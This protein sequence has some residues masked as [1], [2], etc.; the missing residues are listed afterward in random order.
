MED[1]LSAGHP[2][3]DKVRTVLALFAIYIIVRFLI[4]RAS[5]LARSCHAEQRQEAVSRPSTSSSYSP[6]WAPDKKT[7]QAAVYT[8]DMKKR[9]SLTEAVPLGTSGKTRLSIDPNWN[10]DGQAELAQHVV[11]RMPP[12]PPLTPP[13]LSST[14]FNMDTDP[15][16]SVDNFMQQ[17]NPDYMSA[18][19]GVDMTPSSA[20]PSVSAPRLRSYVRTLPV[21]VPTPQ[22]SFQAEADPLSVKFSA[23][24]YPPTSPLLPSAP[25]GILEDEATAG[26][27]GDVD[28][29]GE[30]ISV[31]DKDGAGWTRHTR[32]YGSGVCLAC[33]AH[34]GENGGFYGSAVS[35]EERRQDA[36]AQSR[37][38]GS[39]SMPVQT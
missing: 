37:R 22:Q 20:S 27:A 12:A 23:S 15:T 38:G 30:I 26:A 21:G 31:L 34:G 35:P 11:S 18:T 17:P 29:K 13:E 2:V 24:S 10:A 14:V 4:Q 19:S 36:Y 8:V 9:D 16:D 28:L 39:L 25:P 5:A 33:A 3:L 1:Y 32:V 6:E 7:S